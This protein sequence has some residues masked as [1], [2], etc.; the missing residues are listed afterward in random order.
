[1]KTF[2][3]FLLF[4]FFLS[5]ASIEIYNDSSYTLQAKIYTKTNVELSN[6]TVISGHYIKWQES[7]YNAKDYAKGP[8]YVIFSCPNGDFYGKSSIVAEN[9]RV[10]AQRS[11]GPK[12]CGSHTQPDPHR[13]HEERPPHAKY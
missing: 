10:Y 3:C 9:S 4:S 11:R 8:F 2:V 13:D 1:M 7:P 5:A 12:K 6:M